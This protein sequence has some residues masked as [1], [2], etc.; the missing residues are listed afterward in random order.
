MKRATQYELTR[1]LFTCIITKED[2]ECGINIEN[3]FLN[4][5]YVNTLYFLLETVEPVWRI[6][7]VSR[8]KNVT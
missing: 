5:N 6:I 4:R 3:F 1:N 8:V 7:N 2:M